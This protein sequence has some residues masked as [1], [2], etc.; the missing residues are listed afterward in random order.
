MVRSEDVLKDDQTFV[1]TQSGTLARKGS[2]AA[3]LL[4]ARALD[5]LLPQPSSSAKEEELGKILADIRSLVPTLHAIHLFEFFSP[6]EWLQ[7]QPRS[8]EGRIVIALLYLQQYPQLM[9]RD[10][11]NRLQQIK[12]QVSLETR[13]EIE[14]LLCLAGHSASTL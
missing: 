5:E 8:Q 4:N 9:N 14:Q 12:E 1:Q 2:V 13:Q 11:L 7:A 10:I 3:M 6:L